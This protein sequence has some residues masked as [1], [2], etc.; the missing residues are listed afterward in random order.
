MPFIVYIPRSSR[1]S[2]VQLMTDY[3]Y[4]QLYVNTYAPRKKIKIVIAP[5]SDIEL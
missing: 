2:R 1:D 3:L 5:E 4:N